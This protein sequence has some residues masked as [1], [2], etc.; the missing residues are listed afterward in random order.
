[1]KKALIFLF[2]IVALFSVSPASRVDAANA[3]NWKAGRITDDSIFFNANSM[4]ADDIQAF[5]NSKVPNCDTWGQALFSGSQTRAQYGTSV[6][7]PPPYVCLKNYQENP[8]TREN[9]LNTAGNVTGGWSAAQIIKN[10]ADTYKISPKALLVLLQKEQ[11]L[12]T[13]DWPYKSQYRSA[14]GYGCPDTAPCDAQYYGFYNQVNNAASAF[15]RYATSPQSYR[16]KAGQN[17]DVLFNPIASCGSSSVY[18]QNQATAG[19]YTYTPYQPNQAALNNLYGTGDGCSAYGNRNYWRLFTDWFGPTIGPLIRTDTS[20]DLYYSDGTNKVRVPSIRVM[21]EYGLSLTDVRYV[22][23]TE[24]DSIPLASAPLSESLGLVVKTPSDAD[25]DGASVYLISRGQKLPFSSWQQLVDYGYGTSPIGYV[26]EDIL[27][28]LPV[29]RPVN[30]FAQAPDQSVSKIESGKRHAIFE[31]SKLSELN[32]DGYVTPLSDEALSQLPYSNPLVDGSFVTINPDG[33]V[34]L[35]SS[36]TEYLS[37]PSMH[38]YACA[39]LSAIKTFYPSSAAV[40]NGTLSSDATCLGKTGSNSYIL[41]GTKKYTVTFSSSQAGVTVYPSEVSNVLAD[42]P[43]GSVVKGAGPS[44]WMLENGTLRPIPN[45]IVFSKLGFTTNSITIIPDTALEALIKG[46]QKLLPGIIT[47]DPTGGLS[48]INADSSRL[49]I[50]SLNTISDFNLS[51]DGY[52]KPDPLTFSHYTSVGTL[53][54]FIKTNGNVYLID[55]KVSYFVPNDLYGPFG[56]NPSTLPEANSVLTDKLLT[57]RLTQFIK[58]RSSSA[59]YYVENGQK[60]PVM[61]WQKVVEL[62]GQDSIDVLSDSMVDSLPLGQ[63]L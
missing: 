23:Q 46:P 44:L 63:P 51:W 59:V 17:N 27:K 57:W 22:T 38:V 53:G 50:P 48:I 24:I 4:S 54:K 61:S 29:G 36:Q 62:G 30:N 47:I 56:I 7:N 15:R 31:L 37:I 10:A 32:P 45:M 2:A 20:P 6:G 25:S 8:T 35:Y 52:V 28:T 3:A 18:I 41:A 42:T 9:N 13:D 39:N 40:T 21:Q 12:V 55:G 60:R 19:L 49:V 16:Y 58:K 43:L 33:S 11:A 14:T 34:R 26:S 5:L 1:M